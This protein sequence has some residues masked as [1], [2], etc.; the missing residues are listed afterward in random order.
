M[1]F[2]LGAVVG[3]VCGFVASI[4]QLLAKNMR[5]AALVKLGQ[6]PIRDCVRMKVELLSTPIGALC[7][8][9]PDD[10]IVIAAASALPSLY[11]MVTMVATVGQ[12]RES[13]G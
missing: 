11:A 7:G 4:G 10:Q 9:I 12:I 6:P 3:L 5:N 2:V 8:F 1:S 13:K